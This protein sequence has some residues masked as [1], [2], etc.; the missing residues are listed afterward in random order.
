[1][2][3]GLCDSAEYRTRHPPPATFIES[4]YERLLHRRSDAAGQA[5][6]LRALRDR[7]STLSVI[8]G[9]VRSTEYCAQRLTELHVRMLG[10]EPDRPGLLRCVVA[11]AQGTAL[12]HFALEIATS[13]EYIARAA[14]HEA[15]YGDPATRLPPMCT[16]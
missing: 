9:F 2:I 8:Q 16:R 11:A 15:G 1:V 12:Q 7:A 3:T 14:R 4:L 5:G 10:R 6:W 13:A